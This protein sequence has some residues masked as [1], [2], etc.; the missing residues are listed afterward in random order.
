[1]VCRPLPADRIALVQAGEATVRRLTLSGLGAW[2]DVQLGQDVQASPAPASSGSGSG[3]TFWHQVAGGGRNQLV[4]IEGTQGYLYAFG[5]RALLISVTER[6]VMPTTSGAYAEALL[7]TFTLAATKTEVDFS[8]PG[9]AGLPNEGRGLPF[10]KVRLLT[11]TVPD[12]TPAPSPTQPPQPMVPAVGGVPVPFH[13]VATDLAGHEVDLVQPLLF[14]P[15]GTTP[16]YA[17]AGIPPAAIAGDPVT[18]VPPAAAAGSSAGSATLPTSA[19]SFTLQ[20]AAPGGSG[21]PFV[22]AMTEAAVSVPAIGQL[23]GSAGAAAAAGIAYHS[24]YLSG[25]L[26]VASNAGQVFAQLFPSPT[27]A[28]NSGG[29]VSLPMPADRSGG[30]ASPNL[31]LDGLSSSLGPVAGT[32]GL[33]AA[34]GTFNPATIF[35]GGSGAELLGGIS[36]GEVLQTIAGPF[37]PA[38]LPVLAHQQLPGQLVTTFDWSPPLVSQGVIGG[39]LELLPATTLELHSKTV[40]PISD[41]TASTF[42]LSGTL[43]SFALNFIDG[44]GTVRVEFDHL[45]F[46]AQRGQKVDLST[47]GNVNITFGGMLAFVNELANLL[48]ADGFSDP[49]FLTATTSG[50]TAGYMLG[51]PSAGVGIL[52][53]ENLSITVELDLPFDGAAGMRFAFAERYHPFLVTVALIAGGGYLAVEIDSTGVQR[54]EGSLE[55]G[56]NLTVDLVI[57]SANV[58]VMAGFFF[59]YDATQG[60]SF[61]GYLRIGGSVSLLGIVSISVELVLSLA[62]N[63]DTTPPDALVGTASV[64]VSVSVLMVSKSFTLSVSKRFPVPGG[65]ASAAIGGP[66]ADTFSPSGGAGFGDLMTRGDFAAYCA[67]FA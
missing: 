65:G 61:D 15:D 47:G 6:Q 33:A 34:G 49:P 31:P 29:I 48:P 40:T 13:M 66:S 57:V 10:T 5:F 54:V 60:V 43:T 36:L 53:L 62:Y 46:R 35:P 16:D 55:L 44:D 63:T 59:S 20:P 19:M 32:A 18:Y 11:V 23:L 56:A 9:A 7:T 17:G 52:S 50:V 21:P 3:L 58:H 45:S 27:E 8:D 41:P 14:V 28:G 12:L 30:L 2:A 37:N 64:T 51:V 39:L 42:T 38:Q 26:D 25:G 24:A 67:A 4:K 22:P 1:M